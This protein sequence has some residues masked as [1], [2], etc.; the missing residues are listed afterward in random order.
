M[1]L[2]NTN[3]NYFNSTQK[4]N[5]LFALEFYCTLFGLRKKVIRKNGDKGR[6][7]NICQPSNFPEKMF[8][9]AKKSADTHFAVESRAHHALRALFQAHLST[10]IRFNQRNGQYEGGG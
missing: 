4:N 1:S 3:R 7:D 8:G 10:L 9:Q 6:Q 5:S 2:F